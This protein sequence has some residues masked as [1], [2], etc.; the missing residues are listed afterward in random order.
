MTAADDHAALLAQLR[1]PGACGGHPDGAGLVQTHIS[2]LLLCG[3]QVYKLMRP[4]ALPFVDFSSLDK[5]R[6]AC[7]E[8]LRLN[9][10]T[11]PHWY[12]AVVPVIGAA[13]GACIPAAGRPR[14]D[15]PLLDWALQMRRFDDRLLFSRL[16]ARGELAPL[17]ID[18]LA[19]VLA[20]FHNSL[21]PSPPAFGDPAALQAAA[22]LNLQELATLLASPRWQGLP[23]AAEAAASVVQV[24]AWVARR[25]AELADRM[26][27]RRA[28]GQVREGHG[29]L[30]LANLVWS[31]GAPVLFDALEFDP[32]LRHIDLVGDLAFACMD[33]LA[34]GLPAL[35]WRLAS[36]WLEA[37][38]QHDGLPLLAWWLV[39]RAAVRAKVALLSA[40]GDA[41]GAGL[42]DGLQRY[43]AVAAA[44]SAPSASPPWL[45]LTCGLSGSGKTVV[46]GALAERL[47][48]IRLRS[49]VE[50][51]LLAGLPP[52]VRGGPDLYTPQAG[53]AT[54]AR[55]QQLAGD[56]LAAGVPVVVDAAS[57]QAAERQAMQAVAQRSGAGFRVLVC[58]APLPVLAE[59]VRA[60]LAAGTDASD[61][62]PALLDQQATWA[63][64]PGPDDAAHT[65][66]LDT[67]APLSEVLAR[68][69]SLAL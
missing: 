41:A 45:V 32:A 16:A 30:H 67:D 8:A 19:G 46:A 43:L 34:A 69:Q 61:A 2:S 12:Q 56:A 44:L 39:H 40:P 4:V 65:R 36:A 64:W 22:A 10:R 28:A 51:K 54:Y 11:A 62:T 52:T 1:R 66:W 50:R 29:D 60:R 13:G 25:G 17:H 7:D 58:N 23:G 42:P 38:G 6:A 15:G 5:R 48:G 63:Q 55:L 47:G 26:Q 14:P 20:A 18:A 68:V 57:L 53:A 3:G 49:D 24:Q 9:R 33:L 59:R 35:A 31:D 21:P 37:T 27:Q